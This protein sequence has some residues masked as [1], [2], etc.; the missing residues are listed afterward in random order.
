MVRLKYIIRYFAENY[1]HQDDLS[2]AR[3]TK[4]VYLADWYNCLKN[5]RQLTD[6]EWY[7]DHYGPYVADVYEEVVKDH[8]LVVVNGVNQY[9]SPKQTIKLRHN[10]L[11]I[12]FR[13]RL[14]PETI[15]IL[16]EVIEDTKAFYWS[17]FIDYVYNTYPIKHSKRY[18]KLN[19]QKLALDCKSL[20]LE[21]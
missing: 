3:I 15:E 11:D 19:L 9:G 13:N 2:K 21:I 18:S 4:M 10:H 20:G 8:R 14:A 6:I 1:P 16:D 17:E 5:C 12:I 7:F